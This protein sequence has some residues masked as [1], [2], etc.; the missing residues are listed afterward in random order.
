VQSQSPEHLSLCCASICCWSFLSSCSRNVFTSYVSLPTLYSQFLLK[1]IR[2][3]HAQAIF[4]HT[5]GTAVITHIPPTPQNKKALQSLLL[6]CRALS[7]ATFSYSFSSLSLSF[8]DIRARLLPLLPAPILGAFVRQLNAS[9]TLSAKHKRFRKCDGTPCTVHTLHLVHDNRGQCND[10]DIYTAALTTVFL[11]LHTL[12]ALSTNHFDDL[13][14]ALPAW[15]LRSLS[16]RYG[17][18]L[19]RPQSRNWRLTSL[20]L[21]GIPVAH[22]LLSPFLK[23]HAGTLQELGLAFWRRYTRGD[24]MEL[25]KMPCLRRVKLFAALA[26]RI[27]EMQGLDIGRQWIGRWR[28]RR[29]GGD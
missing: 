16:C 17:S 23:E 26:G 19:L 18:H 1:L 27:R 28:I 29:G 22:E 7:S 11:H 5:E 25:P 2:S 14:A 6:T 12:K 13:P 9:G 15:P 8:G 24:V 20:S 21:W 10:N 3:I 4:P